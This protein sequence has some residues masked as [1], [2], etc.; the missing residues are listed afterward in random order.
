MGVE[1]QWLV[2]AVPFQVL[3]SPFLVAKAS[4]C[5][6]KDH[7]DDASQAYCKDRR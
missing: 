4:D 6:Q 3:A 7:K 2:G 5:G 1:G